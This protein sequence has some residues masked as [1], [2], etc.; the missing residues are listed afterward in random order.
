MNT[1]T[2]LKKMQKTLRSLC[3]A[4]AG[5]FGLAAAVAAALDLPY[6]IDIGF[7]FG[8]A[9][10]MAVLLS[11]PDWNAPT[12]EDVPRY[13]MINPSTGLPFDSRRGLDVSGKPF[14]GFPVD[15]RR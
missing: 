2:N 1:I 15:G 3:F 7:L 8:G 13:D 14:R 5:F 12:L 4:A 9:I 11:Y 10:A 6:V